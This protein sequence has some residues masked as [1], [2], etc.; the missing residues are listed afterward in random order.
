M[1]PAVQANPEASPN[2]QE[3]VTP[4]NHVSFS[5]LETRMLTF[6]AAVTSPRLTLQRT[7]T[8]AYS[9]LQDSTRYEKTQALLERYD[10]DYVPPTPRSAARGAGMPLGDVTPKIS[11]RRPSWP[12][13]T[14][15]RQVRLHLRGHQLGVA[16]GHCNR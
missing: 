6:Q 11:A 15:P 14:L 16:R 3:V 12:P 5:A 2:L 8:Y 9:A 1:A 7:F 13:T 10:P 4:G